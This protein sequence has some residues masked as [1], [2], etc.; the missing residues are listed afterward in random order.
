M[1]ADPF[2]HKCPVLTWNMQGLCHVLSC[3]S[4]LQTISLQKR[5]YQ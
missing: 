5:M 2:V 3:C 1:A 4:A